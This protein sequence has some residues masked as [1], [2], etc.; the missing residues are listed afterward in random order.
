MI[1]QQ[2]EILMNRHITL[3]VLTIAVFLGLATAAM[4]LWPE[5]ARAQDDQGLSLITETADEGYALAVTL[6]RRGVS[7]TQPDREV[8][9]SL[10]EEYATDPELLIAS[11]QVIAIHFQTIAEANNYWRD[12]E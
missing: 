3:R 9:F 12:S 8:L 10:R 6:A 11:S 5:L 2:R 7:T 1:T 4:V